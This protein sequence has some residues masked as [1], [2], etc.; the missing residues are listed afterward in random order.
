M[1]LGKALPTPCPHQRCPLMEGHPQ[2]RPPARR[3]PQQQNL[4]TL[5]DN[6]AMENE[7]PKHQRR[8][9]Q[10]S[11]RTLLIGVT[12]LA[13][14]CA[15]VGSHAKIIH[16]RKAMLNKLTRLEGACL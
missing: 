4:K 13:V 9:F 6:E 15:Y 5:P 3:L 7:P 8:W 14:P 2:G 1:A 12:L 11:L 10:F 16:R